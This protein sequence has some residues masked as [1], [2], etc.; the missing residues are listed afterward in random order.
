MATEGLQEDRKAPPSKLVIVDDHALVRKGMKSMLDGEPDLRVIGEASDGRE[1]LEVCRSLEPDLIL[2]DVRMPTMDGL[3]ATQAIKQEL[4]STSVLMV[5][6]Y[7][8]QDYLYEALKA[9]A[10]GY[11]LKES[12]QEEVLGAVRRVLSG[13]SSL[14][15]GLAADLLQRLVKEKEEHRAQAVVSPLTTKEHP[16]VPPEL[17]TPRETEI[18]RLVAQ[19]MTNRQIAE[20]LVASSATVKT[21]VQHIIAKLGVSD[22]TQAAVCA[23]EL[24]LC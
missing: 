24:G 3:A 18:V 15:P 16:Q 5:T 9:G 10:A 14:S 7:E 8:N 6:M 11:V 20:K 12:G 23:I 4:P 13:E 17:L 2:M 21:H 22:R 1:A 19:G